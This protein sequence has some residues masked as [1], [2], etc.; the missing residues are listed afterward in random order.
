[1]RVEGLHPPPRLFFTSEGIRAMR[2]RM[3]NA[4]LADPAQFA[5]VRRE[6]AIDPARDATE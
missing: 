1:M 5:H 6:L 2:A 3:A 4:L